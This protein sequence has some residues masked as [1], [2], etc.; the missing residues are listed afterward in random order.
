M[1]SKLSQATRAAKLTTPLGPDELVIVRFDATEGLSELFEYRIEALSARDIDFDSILGQQCSV[2]I[3]TYGL[4]RHFSGILVEAQWTGMKYEDHVYRLV[5]RPWLWLH[6]RESDCRIFQ[7]KT[8]PDIIKEVLQGG[9]LKLA[10]Q[11]NPYPQ[12]IY[13]VQY[14]ETDLAFVSRLMEH[15]GIYYFFEHTSDKH[16]LV[17]ADSMSS[18][19]PVPGLASIPY[20][21]LGNSE[22]R[23]RQHIYHWVAER[24]FRTGKV[25]LNDYNE[26]EPNTDLKAEKKGSARYTK[27]NLEFYD[28]PGKYKKK[29]DG[30]KY[31]KVAL[32]AEQALDQRRHTAGNAVNLFPGGLTNVDG[33]QKG[34]ENAEFLVVR[35]SHAYVAEHYRSEAGVAEEDYHG[36]FELL[37]KNGMVF[38]APIVTPKPL[39]HGI[40]TAVVTGP[41]GEEIY[42]DEYGRIKVQFHWDRYGKKDE[43]SSCW[44][45]VAE[46]WSGKKWGTQET[47]RIGMEVMVEFLEGDPDQPLVAGTVYN[48]EYK[49]PY[50]LPTNK[51][52]SG[53]KSNSSKGGGGFNQ[54]RFEDKKGSE[55]INMHAQ[56]DYQ[57]TVLDS[58]KR[59]IGQRFTGQLCAP[60]SRQ[61][62]LLMGDD[63]LTVATGN[64]T[65]M[66]A[67]NQT[68]TYGINHTLTVGAAQTN[69]IGATQTTTA[70]GPITITSMA[71]ITLVC[72]ASTIM[73]TPAG[74]V[75]RAPLIAIQSD[76][77]LAIKGMPVAIAGAAMGMT[78]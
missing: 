48:G 12:L 38:R 31:A 69:T 7:N 36:N 56:K 65:I 23:D 39:I 34:S 18:H 70:G 59:E 49:H 47:P 53:I 60:Y 13:C 17:L 32:E 8:A 20:I 35:A 28:Y 73:L 55:E 64:Q 57:I 24:R 10:L 71:M 51:T 3:S 67:M 25:M 15:H 26:L 41:S 43:K 66:I 1:D 42:V 75:I 45:R 16:T 37:P 19:Q 29:N 54:Y 40:Q 78:F 27:S 58:E 77:P 14:R 33:H 61:T 21:P 63:G 11:D 9:D 4:D 5:L 52:Q 68:T 22:R 30:E 72:G 6:S 2:K 62:T 50:E 74:I 46:R 76:G 44:I